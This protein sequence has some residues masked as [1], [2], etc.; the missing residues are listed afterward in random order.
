MSLSLVPLLVHSN[1]V[2]VEV[3]A[4]LRAAQGAAPDGRE[5]HLVRAARL[6]FARGELECAEVRELVGLPPGAC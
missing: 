2:P 3:R 4:E 5:E 1:D 6:L